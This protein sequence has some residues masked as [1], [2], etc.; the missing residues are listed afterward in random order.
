MKER[1]QNVRLKIMW[2]D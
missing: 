1:S 2:K